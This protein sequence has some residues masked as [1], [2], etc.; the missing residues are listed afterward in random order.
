MKVGDHLY[1]SIGKGML[2]AK[3]SII[4]ANVDSWE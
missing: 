3:E 2:D 1:T 4:V